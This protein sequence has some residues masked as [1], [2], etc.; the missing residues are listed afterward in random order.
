VVGLIGTVHTLVCRRL[1]TNHAFKNYSGKATLKDITN[2]G[3]TSKFSCPN[4]LLQCLSFISYEWMT[5]LS[6]DMADLW[7]TFC[8]MNQYSYAPSPL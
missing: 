6:V 1:K 4:D 3:R 2:P 8:L 7:S 5:V